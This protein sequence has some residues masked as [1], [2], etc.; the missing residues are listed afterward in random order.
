VA[1]ADLRNVRDAS[2]RTAPG[3]FVFCNDDGYAFGESWWRKRFAAALKKA[4]IED[5]G[6]HLTP[7]CLRHSVATLLAAEGVDPGHISAALGW[8]SEE[9]RLRYTHLGAEH[10]RDVADAL[11][12]V[13]APEATTKT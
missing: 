4:R 5:R 6:R 10:L 9:M 1:V 13:L 2:I 7:H 12:R 3:D 11:G 8:G